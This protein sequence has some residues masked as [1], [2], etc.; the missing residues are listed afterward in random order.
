MAESD[1]ELVDQARTIIKKLNDL[2]AE[3]VDSNLCRKSWEGFYKWLYNNTSK[4]KGASAYFLELKD[5]LKKEYPTLDSRV[6]NK[7]IE[8]FYWYAVFLETIRETFVYGFS[9]IR[10]LGKLQPYNENKKFSEL[11]TG[12]QFVTNE[13][14]KKADKLLEKYRQ[15]AKK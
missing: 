5:D 1:E 3:L 10:P 15:E 11:I 8:A 7:D 4:D 13:H 14:L 12:F 2:K 9:H 6:H